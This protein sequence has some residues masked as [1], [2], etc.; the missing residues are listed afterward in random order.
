[1]MF[2]GEMSN[3]QTVAA[4]ILPKLTFVGRLTGV[5]ESEN[6]LNRFRVE[7]SDDDRRFA[8]AAE[9][10]AGSLVETSQNL[11]DSSVTK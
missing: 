10:L 11:F 4:S 2:F 7:I 9:F 8:A 1:M 3:R 6:G 5:D